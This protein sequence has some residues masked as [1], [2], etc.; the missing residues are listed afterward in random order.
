M[1]K[2]LHYVSLTALAVTLAAFIVPHITTRQDWL[3]V[4]FAASLITAIVTRLAM[5]AQPDNK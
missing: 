1:I 2:T 4:A 5:D 3:F